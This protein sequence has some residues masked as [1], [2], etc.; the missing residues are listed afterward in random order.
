MQNAT[1][2]SIGCH[3]Q[4]ESSDPK[5]LNLLHTMPSSIVEERTMSSMCDIN[6]HNGFANNLPIVVQGRSPIYSTA[7]YFG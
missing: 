5:Q 4:Y 1:V 6:N 7:N 2:Q 3:Y